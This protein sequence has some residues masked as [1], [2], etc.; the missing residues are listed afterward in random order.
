M[1]VPRISIEN[2]DL[3]SIP[4]LLDKEKIAFQPIDKI[5]W[6]SYPYK[7]VVNFRIAHT[8]TNIIL[9]YAV[10]ENSI[11]AKYSE[12]NDMVW[13][14][15]CVEF[16]AAFPDDDIYYNLECN[17]I[18]TILLGVGKDRNKREKAP[19]S[20]TNNIK[21]W[22]SLGQTTF[23]KRIGDCSWQIVLVIPYTSFFKHSIECMKGK[24]MKANF[25][26]CGDELT[27]PH[28][29]SWKA[30]DAPKPDFHLPKF[31]G[32]IEFE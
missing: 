10:T 21:R 14:D 4:N 31:F 17:C 13:T 24:I 6:P 16:F 2:I 22:S 3:P 12:D 8:N 11:R 9:E 5:N 15:S 18:G 30:I 1:I 32:E 23:D 26:K 19:L 7:P 29:L 27:T 20:I 25:Y 28:F